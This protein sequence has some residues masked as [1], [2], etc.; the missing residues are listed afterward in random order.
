GGDRRS[1]GK[2]YIGF[3]SCTAY[4]RPRFSWTNSIGM[5]WGQSHKWFIRVEE[6]RRAC[7]PRRSTNSIIQS[8]PPNR[9]HGWSI[10]SRGMGRG[11]MQ[12]STR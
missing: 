5:R 1:G 12:T 11:Q 8:L 6:Q 7:L 2:A 9:Y 3:S 10:G 4:L